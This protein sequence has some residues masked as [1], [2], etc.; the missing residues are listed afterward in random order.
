M[1][2]FSDDLLELAMLHEDKSLPTNIHIAYLMSRV[3][4]SS[5]K[6]YA[7]TEYCIFHIDPMSVCT[8]Y[9]ITSRYEAELLES[10]FGAGENFTDQFIRRVSRKHN[11]MLRRNIKQNHC[12][13]LIIMLFYNI[14]ILARSQDAVRSLF[15]INIFLLPQSAGR[16]LDVSTI[17]HSLSTYLTLEKRSASLNHEAQSVSES[18]HDW[19]VK[20]HKCMLLVPLSPDSTYPST[21]R[22]PMYLYVACKNCMAPTLHSS[23]VWSPG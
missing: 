11:R 1:F 4:S 8:S 19:P 12:S 16:M 7:P 2:R 5:T 10:C 18:R 15:P 23:S 21:E 20:C 13:L 3:S 22:L 14:V 9:V 17:D 6:I